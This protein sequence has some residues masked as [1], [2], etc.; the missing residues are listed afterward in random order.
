[1]NRLGSSKIRSQENFV[2][3]KELEEELGRAREEDVDP[4]D[5]EKAQVGLW[6]T[7]TQYSQL[8]TTKKELSKSL[9]IVEIN[10]I[11]WSFKPFGH[12]LQSD[13]F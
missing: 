1:M 10:K 2:A 6:K 3:I 8:E 12:K 13:Y 9:S 4:K 5:V 11:Q 7:K